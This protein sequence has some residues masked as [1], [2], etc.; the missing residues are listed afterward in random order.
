M[1]KE[2]T[3]CFQSGTIVEVADWSLPSK[4]HHDSMT[5]PQD[6][7]DTAADT[8]SATTFSVDEVLSYSSRWDKRITTD[9]VAEME[10]L[11][12][13]KI[14]TLPQMRNILAVKGYRGLGRRIASDVDGKTGPDALRAM[15]DA[16][17]NFA[18]EHPGLSAATFRNAESDSPDW[19]EAGAELFGIAH[20]VFVQVDIEGEHAAQALRILRSLVRGFVISEMAASFFVEPAEYQ[21][22]FDRGIDV[23]ICGLPAL[24][25]PSIRSVR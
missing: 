10:N 12:G 24:L 23:F 4:G 22:E 5:V 9:L 8:A 14:A 13:E 20:R 15:A 25:L 19:Q 7:V 2:R 3:S 17:R 18:L 16:M 6:N 1:I 11:L 21:H